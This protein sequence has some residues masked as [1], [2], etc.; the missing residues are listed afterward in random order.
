MK[1]LEKKP[2]AY[3]EDTIDNINEVLEENFD[4]VFESSESLLDISH[5]LWEIYEDYY[6]GEE[7]N[8]EIFEDMLLCYYFS[9][10]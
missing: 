9:R 2:I 8:R 10:T 5:T 4:D 3:I 7:S 1:K 6:D